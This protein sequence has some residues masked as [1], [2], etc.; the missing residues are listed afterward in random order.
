MRM[1]KA[2]VY[3]IARMKRELRVE[4]NA[5]GIIGVV[6]FALEI[7]SAFTVGFSVESIID[8][9]INGSDA[10]VAT[11]GAIGIAGGIIIK[12][13]AFKLTK[14]LRRSKIQN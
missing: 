4:R 1:P 10:S 13:Q 2:K 6:G 8:N 5:P 3:N 14:L 9:G 12:K 11:I 7:A